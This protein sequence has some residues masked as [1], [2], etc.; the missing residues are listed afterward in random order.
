M[1]LSYKAGNGV[2]GET[3]YIGAKGAAVIDTRR[4]EV[5]RRPIALIRRVVYIKYLLAK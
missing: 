5:V 3:A 2:R 1:L 4:T